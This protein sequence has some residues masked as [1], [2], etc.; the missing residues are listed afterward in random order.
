MGKLLDVLQRPGRPS[1]R[2]VERQCRASNRALARRIV[3]GATIQ[4]TWDAAHIAATR[5]RRGA[6]GLDQGKECN[7]EM[8]PRDVSYRPTPLERSCERITRHPSVQLTHL[9]SDRRREL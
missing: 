2:L 7:V 6:A 9:N 8:L 3:A 4:P 1:R 5:L